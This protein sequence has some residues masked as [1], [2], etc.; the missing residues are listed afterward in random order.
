MKKHYLRMTQRI[1]LTLLWA[2]LLSQTTWAQSV[3]DAQWAR[4]GKTLAITT[5][6]NIAT[7]DGAKV[8]KY[9]L[10]GNKLLETGLIGGTSYI[11]GKIQGCPSCVPNVNGYVPLS[12]VSFTMPTANGGVVLLGREFSTGY[13]VL[14]RL[15]A[16]FGQ[17]GTAGG[18]DYVIGTPDA[19]LLTL[20]S[21]IEYNDTRTKVSLQKSGPTSWS[22]TVFFPAPDPA[23][24]DVSL[25]KANVVINTPDGGYLVAGFF[26]QAGANS[27]G[28]AWVAKLDGQGNVSWQRLLTG[29]PFD[30]SPGNINA[31]KTITDAMV[32]ADGTGYVLVGLGTGLPQTVGTAIVEI[33]GNGTIRKAKAIDTQ[34]TFAYITAYGGKGG[35]AY[36]AVGNTSIQNRVDPQL[37]LVDPASLSGV[38]RRIFQGPGESSLVDIGTA[39]DGSLV[40]ATNNN[41]VVKLLP[42]AQPTQPTGFSLLS[43]TYSC[44]TGAITFNTS[45]GDG[46]P[47]TYSAPGIVRSSATSNT[48]TVEQGLRNDPKVIPITATQSGV[49][50]TYTFDLRAA[51]SNT[52]GPKAPI[53]YTIPDLTFTVGQDVSF[54]FGYNFSDP[55]SNVPNYY[56]DWL[57][58]V[59]GLPDGL[60]LEVRIP[61][62]RE[63]Y[64]PILGKP[65]T[66]GTY[67]VNVTA[68]TS[69]FRNSPIQTSFRIT[70]LPNGQPPVTPPPPPNP[71][72]GGSL[73]QTQPTYNCA[74]GAITFNTSGGD[75]SPITFSAPGIA[76]SSASSNTG[77]VEQ[78]L[79][80]D[81]KSLTI[82]AMQSGQT[83]TYVF[84]FNA[85]CAN[86]QPPAPPT[87]P[88]P[89]ANGPLSL[90]APTYD[91]GS[92]AITFRTSGGNG[93]AVEFAS[94]G[95]TGWTTNPNQFVDKD[96]RTANDVKPF[97]LMARQ[98]G[99]MVTYV[100]DLK[101]TCGRGVSARLGASELGSALSVV[102]L[103]NPV[104][105]KSVEVEIQGAEGQALHL[106]LI[107]TQGRILHQQRIDKADSTERVSVP[108]G[109]SR[110]VLL[111]NV[112]TAT[113][114]QQVKLLKP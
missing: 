104:E 42:A 66:A 12:D 60:R 30:N 45:G 77:T 110:G 88:T 103:G 4:V 69:G 9:D 106:N 74:T 50:V 47:I 15:T 70:I 113:Q 52:P 3:P 102:V 13:G 37:I 73:S 96:S 87:P 25:T 56:P 38:A 107:D 78:G 18:V 26:N 8:V 109:N 83:A 10:N 5:D 97:T 62:S 86:P 23:T 32:S 105:G 17:I 85:Y 108:V 11:G 61:Y 19:G 99:V 41:Q 35:K 101:A 57:F 33:D 80:N 24:P 46:S 40:F 75:G 2:G 49:S 95:I 114:R 93:S 79:R 63:P 22:R 44:Q 82:T 89:P 84:D 16:N 31:M 72:T 39:G 65:T 6:G 68:S 34:A 54:E 98:N 48:G 51:C 59:Q 90:L 111:L 27:P 20:N 21:V 76:R 14:A 58:D 1:W 100:W 7:G 55:T 112:N 91:C 43:P 81:P 36:Y 92:G 71:P 64:A 67:T 29:F 28:T 53:Y 94:P